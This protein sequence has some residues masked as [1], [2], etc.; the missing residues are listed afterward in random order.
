[1]MMKIFLIAVILGSLSQMGLAVAHPEKTWTQ[2]KVFDR[3]ISIVLENA[4]YSKVITHPYFQKLMSE[5]SLL[6][7]FEAIAHPSYPNY[8]AMIAGK[9]YFTFL[10]AQINVDDPNLADLLEAK[11]LTWKNYA[12][13]YP[14]GCFLKDSLGKYARKHVPFLSFKSIQKNPARCAR[15]VNEN[16]FAKDWALRTLPDYS[17][18]TPNLDHD[19]HDTN[20]DT[21]ANWLKGFLEPLLN[22]KEGMRGT[23]IEITFDEAGSFIGKNQIFTLLLGPSVKAGAQISTKYNVYSFLRTIEENFELKSL[24]EEDFEAQSIQNVWR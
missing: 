3:V 1:M 2:G 15:V 9:K 24:G 18:Y 7:Q 17:M 22:D 12:E 14:G 4:D 10:D 20:L 11:G 13:G 5:G 19:G 6:T 23:L 8:L 21:A 16:E